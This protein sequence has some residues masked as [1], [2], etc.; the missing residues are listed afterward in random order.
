MR[1]V[2]QPVWARHPTRRADQH[3]GCADKHR[4]APRRQYAVS[5]CY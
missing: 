1:K 5:G 4:D 3:H 2:D